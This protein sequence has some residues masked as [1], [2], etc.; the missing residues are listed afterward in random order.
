MFPKVDSP[1]FDNKNLRPTLDFGTIDKR[2]LV[3]VKIKVPTFLGEIL[4]HDPFW[5]LFMKRWW[6]W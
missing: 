4:W 6:N 2:N 5:I 1:F 3:P